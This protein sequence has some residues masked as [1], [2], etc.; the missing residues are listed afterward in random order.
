M[1]EET[2]RTTAGRD[3]VVFSCIEIRSSSQPMNNATEVAEA[4]AFETIAT[5]V[6]VFV[7]VGFVL[8]ICCVAFCRNF[9]SNKLVQS[10]SSG[11]LRACCSSITN[12]FSS[13]IRACCGGNRSQTYDSLDQNYT[14]RRHSSSGGGGSWLVRLATCWYCCGFFGPRTE[15]PQST[16]RPLVKGPYPP[17]PA[18]Y[19]KDDVDE[20]DG[21]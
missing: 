13:S 11:S 19:R 6:Y 9:G 18:E 4:D 20:P 8:C 17:L 21:V 5:Y 3:N 7:I 2:R 15:E 10:V 14:T 1:V 12:C 16:R